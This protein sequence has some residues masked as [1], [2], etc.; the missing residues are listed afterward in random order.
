MFFTF[1]FLVPSIQCRKEVVEANVPSPIDLSTTVL[2][3]SVWR[4]GRCHHSLEP[5][6]TVFG[7]EGGRWEERRVDLTE[8][9][10][11]L[12]RGRYLND[13][14]HFKCDLNLLNEHD[15]VLKETCS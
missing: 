14:F 10:R 5:E 8:N 9:P 4:F 12:R 2:K 1:T 7:R 13:L 6:V 11:T 3:P 15:F